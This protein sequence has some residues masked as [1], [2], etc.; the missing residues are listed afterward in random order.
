ML[1][2]SLEGAIAPAGNP[3]PTTLI[4]PR[5]FPQRLLTSFFMGVGM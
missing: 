4:N 3:R 5:A 2:Q 1:T